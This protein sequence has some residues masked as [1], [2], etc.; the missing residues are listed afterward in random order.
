MKTEFNFFKEIEEELDKQFPKGKCKERGN[1]LV[2]YTIMHLKFREFVKLL[3][4]ELCECEFLGEFL[5]DG[6]KC[7][8][9]RI[10][11]KLSG[12]NEGDN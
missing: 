7:S 12:L 3:K 1:A 4:E 2:L 5:G 9:C 10:I 11:D 8:R 6:I